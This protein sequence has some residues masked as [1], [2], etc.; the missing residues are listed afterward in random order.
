MKMTS[1]YVTLTQ[2][3]EWVHYFHF[4]LA[5]RKNRARFTTDAFFTYKGLIC[6]AVRLISAV[7]SWPLSV[8]CCLTAVQKLWLICKH[9]T[10]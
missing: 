3:K 4:L 7:I 9:A 8:M 6:L 5:S 2:C 1:V 10:L